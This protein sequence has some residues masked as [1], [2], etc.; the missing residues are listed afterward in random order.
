MGGG[1]ESRSG[2]SDR[3]EEMDKVSLLK[4]IREAGR[5]EEEEW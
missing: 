5:T 3:R 4:K 2:V 1:D